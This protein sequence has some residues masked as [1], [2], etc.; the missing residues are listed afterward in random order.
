V[1]RPN[2]SSGP[3]VSIV[4]P[5]HNQ[6]D[7]IAATLHGFADALAKLPTRTELIVVAN[8]CTD[9]TAATCIDA[10]ASIPDLRVIEEAKGGWGR[11]V[12]RGL[13][14]AR[15]DVLCYTNSART[16]NETLV[17]MIVYA[18]AYPA[19]V[20]KANRRLR[21]SY[22]RRFGSLL[23]NLECRLLFDLPIWD[24]NGTPKVFPRTFDALLQL[25]RDDDLIDIEFAAVCQRAGYPIIEVPIQETTRRSGKS[26]TNFRSAA[27]MYWGAIRLRREFESSDELRTS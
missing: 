19:V 25:K 9:D 6:A 18:S 17:L 22:L 10:A 21:E 27:R 1:E 3:L 12:R 7:H 14:E 5:V 2:H 11:A 26:T 23:Y 13:S 16:T 24:I 4:L 20:L 15:G 8:A